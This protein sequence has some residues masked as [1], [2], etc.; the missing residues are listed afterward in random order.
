MRHG[1]RLDPPNRFDKIGVDVDLEQ[2]E[3]DDEYLKS[4]T[5]RPIEYFDDTSKSVVS[6]NDSPDISFRYS[7]NPYRGCAHA[8]PYCYA[9]NSHEYLGLNAGMDFETKIYVKRDAVK[10]LREF[11][12]RDGW[13]PA[14][15]IFSGITDCYQPAERE[16]RLTRQ[17][18]EVLCECGA[19]GSIVTKNALVVR[20][21]DLLR[22]M[23]SRRLMQV[24]I[25][26]TTLDPELAR[27]MEPRASIPSARLRAVRMLADAGVPVIVMAAPM[28]PGLNDHEAPAIIEA[29]AAA[30]A[31]DVRY[32]L[33]R[34]PLS[35][36][37]VFL[38]WLQREQPLKAGRIEGLIR[39]MRGG[40]LN[41]SAFGKR[42]KGEGKIAEQIAQ[43]F[44]V[45]RRKHS[46]PGL[47][48]LDLSRFKPPAAP[49][50]QMRLF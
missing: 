19:A 38:E 3:W 31:K 37:P 14:P 10:L 44:Q 35:V 1:S 22:E 24:A 9:R 30:G 50:G 48:P 27:L 33:L 41:E 15:I 20:D 17:C 4:R 6:E 23:A 36:A 43:V 13:E 46:F 49:N 21:L 11:L 16:F 40:K 34:L 47:Q 5:D 2:L 29:A 18:L 45:F 7:V 32:T 39:Q 42:M 26:V 12:S 28:I 25:S 8:C